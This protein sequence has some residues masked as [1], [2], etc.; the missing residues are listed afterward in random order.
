M[1]CCI[2]LTTGSLAKGVSMCQNLEGVGLVT[3]VTISMNLVAGDLGQEADLIQEE[4]L[5]PGDLLQGGPDQVPGQV[6]DLVTNPGQEMHQGEDLT[7]DMGPDGARG[8]GEIL[9][10]GET[11]GTAQGPGGALGEDLRVAG[12]PAGDLRVGMRGEMAMTGPNPGVGVGGVMLVSKL[13][14][15]VALL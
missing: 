12:D 15:L 11:L 5:A 14:H 3:D 8:P 7:Q 1:A 13:Y 9:G 2:P 10:L 4:D 6:Q